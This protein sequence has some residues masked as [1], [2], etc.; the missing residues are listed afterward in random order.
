[1]IED[2]GCCANFGQLDLKAV[3]VSCELLLDPSISDNIRAL[4][5]RRD[6]CR[7]RLRSVQIRPQRKEGQPA[8][9]SLV[10]LL[11]APGSSSKV[12]RR[13]DSGDGANR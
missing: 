2:A 7:P 9:G 12:E 5:R 6:A 3:N 8:S 11:L 13:E 10:A 1:M 4:Q